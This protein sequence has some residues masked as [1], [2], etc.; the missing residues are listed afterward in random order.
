MKEIY[1][2]I[3]PIGPFHGMSDVAKDAEAKE[4]ESFHPYNFRIVESISN[5]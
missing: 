2:R 1:C 3:L 5:K 4:N